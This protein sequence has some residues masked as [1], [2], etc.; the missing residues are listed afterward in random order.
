MEVST[1]AICAIESESVALTTS[2]ETLTEKIDEVASSIEEMEF[3]HCVCGDAG[4]RASG[5][6]DRTWYNDE[7]TQ[8]LAEAVQ[9]IVFRAQTLR[10]GLAGFKT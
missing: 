8:Q 5:A 4:R 6:W 9:R 10:P 3:E 2:S 7:S 1:E